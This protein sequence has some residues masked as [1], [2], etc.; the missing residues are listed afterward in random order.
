MSSLSYFSFDGSVSVSTVIR[1]LLSSSNEL[2][3]PNILTKESS[4]FV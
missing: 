1:D 3:D 4:V 2:N